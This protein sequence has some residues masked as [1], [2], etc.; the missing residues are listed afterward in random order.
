MAFHSRLDS[1]TY[2]EG[3]AN[4]KPI[5]GVFALPSYLASQTLFDKLISHY[6]FSLGGL[7]IEGSRKILDEKGGSLQLQLAAGG[8]FTHRIIVVDIL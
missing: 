6:F 4:S 7:G 3:R 5:Y 1:A 2:I 8:P